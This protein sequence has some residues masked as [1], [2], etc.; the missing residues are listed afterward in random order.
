[1]TRPESGNSKLKKTGKDRTS[2][3]GVPPD[4]RGCFIAF[5]A[6]LTPSDIESIRSLPARENMKIHFHGFG[7][8]IRNEW[9][10]WN[11][12]VLQKY[13][14]E[15]DVK[16]ADRMSVLILEYYYD[17][18]HGDHEKWMKFDQKTYLT[19]L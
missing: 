5:D 11:G 15:R 6:L 17:W 19:S 18:L 7:T 16:H 10:L 3:A 14:L 1:M 13:F 12:S 4:L 8:W 9:G 2:A